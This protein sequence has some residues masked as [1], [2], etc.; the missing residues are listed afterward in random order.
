MATGAGQACS[1]FATARAVRHPRCHPSSG[2]CATRGCGGSRSRAASISTHRSPSSASAV[3]FLHGKHSRADHDAALVIAV[4]Q[5]LAV[6]LRIGIGRYSDM[7]DEA[8][9]RTPGRARQPDAAGRLVL[10]VEI[11]GELVAAAPL[12]V[13]AEPLKDAFPRTANIRSCSVCRQVRAQVSR[14]RHS[15][16]Q[17]SGPRASGCA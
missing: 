17:N 2:R 8:V 15:S 12:D 3:L 11:D 9:L 4:A 13:D 7:G 16:R 5:I 14:R 6:G 1:F 10:L